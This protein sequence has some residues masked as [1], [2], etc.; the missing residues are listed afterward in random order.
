MGYEKVKN[1]ITADNKNVNSLFNNFDVEICYF[2]NPL[3]NSD[4]NLV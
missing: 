2:I 1:N 3:Q 4:W